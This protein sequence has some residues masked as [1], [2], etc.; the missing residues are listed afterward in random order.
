MKTF[1][2]RYLISRII[3]AFLT[4]SFRVG[5]ATIF[6]LRDNDNATARQHVRASFSDKTNRKPF[7]PQCLTE[8]A[9][10]NLAIMQ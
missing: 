8:V 6:Q 7:R 10:T 5:H 3:A 2:K 4:E 1:Q 9:A